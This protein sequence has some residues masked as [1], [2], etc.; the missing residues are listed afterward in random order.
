MIKEFLVLVER[1]TDETER[2][3][4]QLLKCMLMAEDGPLGLTDTPSVRKQDEKSML[5]TPSNGHVKG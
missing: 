4:R 3:H 5:I 2:L 1:E